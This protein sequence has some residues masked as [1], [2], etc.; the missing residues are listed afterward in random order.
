MIS[1]RRIIGCRISAVILLIAGALAVGMMWQS[2]ALEE[3]DHEEEVE[4]HAEHEGHDHDEDPQEAHDD[5]DEHGHDK[6]RGKEQH[7]DDA[8]GDHEDKHAGHGHDDHAEEVLRLT[9]EQRSHFR[10]VTEK[11]G[12]SSLRN[13]VSLPGE[14]VFNEDLVVHLAPRVA[15]IVRKVNKT[16]GDRIKAGEVLAVIDSRELADAKT[17]YMAAKAREGLADTN[18]EREKFL[19]EKLVS[20]E[21]DHL[22]ARQALA[23]AR[24]AL[25]SAE[26]K[27]HALGFS[28]EDL[29][30]LHEEHGESITRYEITSPISGVII[31]KHISLGE[32]LEERSEIFTVA[33]LGVVWVNLTVYIKNLPDVRTGQSVTLRLDHSGEKKHDVID[34][35]TPFVDES[36]RS[37]TA[38]VVINNSD[39]RWKPG[40]FVTGHIS[41]SNEDV[42]VVVPKSAVQLIGNTKVV[43]IEDGD[44]Y[45]M[46]P[47]KTGREDRTSIEIV[48]GLKP[49]KVYV[50][51]GAFELKAMIVTNNLGSHAGHGH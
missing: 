39:N 29:E 3:N 33:D 45:K 14:I 16:L 48:Q 27:L 1:F 47:V 51:K 17:E 9:P 30:K 38:R 2:S 20:S 19:R 49:G 12:Q 5:H 11:A 15:G 4:V 10:V 25:R 8:H 13:K 43:F 22:A 34:M 7:M 40:T 42:P 46:V 36:T 28:D 23:E 44:A 6:G 21:Q 26:Q 24:V 35:V 41:I 50:A 37:A 32:S 31:E 18:H